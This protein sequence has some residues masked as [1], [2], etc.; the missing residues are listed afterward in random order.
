MSAKELLYG[1]VATVVPNCTGVDGGTYTGYIVQKSHFGGTVIGHSIKNVSFVPGDVV[2]IIQCGECLTY[3]GTDVPLHGWGFLPYSSACPSVLQIPEYSLVR[4]IENNQ[5]HAAT[6][7][8]NWLCR[9]AGCVYKL[10]WPA[11][12][13][14]I[15]GS[16]VTVCDQ[17][18]DGAYQMPV[19]SDL[20]IGDFSVDDY[21]LVYSPS[22]GEEVI[23]WWMMEPGGA[24][25]TV[26]LSINPSIAG[27]GISGSVSLSLTNN[28]N[29][30]ASGVTASYTNTFGA[31]IN[32][33]TGTI[34]NFGAIAAG[35]TKTHIE[36]ITF[37][38]NKPT[39]D[40]YSVSVVMNDTSAKTIFDGAM[41]AD[42]SIGYAALM[43]DDFKA[44]CSITNSIGEHLG[45]IGTM[46]RDIGGSW[47]TFAVIYDPPTPGYIY[48]KYLGSLIYTRGDSIIE[49]IDGT[50]FKVVFTARGAYLGYLVFD[51]TVNETITIN[52]V[53]LQ[54]NMP[55][56][57]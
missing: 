49:N 23:G 1:V 41:S 27:R 38:G 40:G 28:G 30:A 7:S 26:S 21:V 45:Y 25:I 11:R 29:R 6:A 55:T 15:S 48:E 33:L 3:G 5:R 53:E 44:T 36:S 12:I 9:K 56:H 13:T 22:S 54:E 37:L 17:F 8:L 19:S 42:F 14:A 50:S 52:S 35:E 57:Y 4:D 10:Y 39:T 43:W 20:S 46:F 31:F 32:D 2:R 24:I 18:G 34:W 47:N 51:I 16:L